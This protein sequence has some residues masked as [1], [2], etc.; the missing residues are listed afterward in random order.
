MVIDAVRS[1]EIKACGMD[2]VRS[3]KKLSLQRQTEALFLEEGISGP[4][5]FFTIEDID[6]IRLSGVVDSAEEKEKVERVVKRIKDIR[7]VANDLIIFKA[8]M[9]GA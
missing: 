7:R 3:L 6:A 1:D 5:L 2:S 4:H 8:S 9:A